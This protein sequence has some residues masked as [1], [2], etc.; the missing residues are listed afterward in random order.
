MCQCHFEQVQERSK[1]RI[2]RSAWLRAEEEK[3]KE[4]M[5]MKKRNVVLAMLVLATPAWAA[6]RII[7]EPT[8]NTAAIKYATDGEKVRAFALDITASKGVITD[9]NDFIRG[10]STAAKPGYGIFPANFSRYITVNPD[11]GEVA[12]WDVNDYTPVADPC[13]PGA[14]GGLGTNGITIEMG[15]LYYPTDDASPNAPPNSGTLFKLTLSEAASLTVTLNEVRGGVV[16]TDP[17][18]AATVDLSQATNVGDVGEDVFP[19]SHPDYA[20]WVAVGKP[21]C[22]AYPRQCHGD[23]DGRAEGDSKTGYH[24][25]GTLDLNVL[26]AAWMVLEQ[27]Q[28]P[29][30]ASIQNGICA[31]FAHDVGGDAKTGWYRVGTT[32]LNRLTTNWLV[33]DPNVPGDCGGTLEP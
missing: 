23:T 7:I 4:G 30:I 3:R 12:A 28:G 31:D 21:Q 22:W 2:M 17:E 15:A 13:D 27:P 5:T 32:D 11:N 25:V 24:Y 10:E 16:L 9:I 6:V 20:Q 14:L 8:G 33:K 1:T 26:Q 19:A 18:V 29:G